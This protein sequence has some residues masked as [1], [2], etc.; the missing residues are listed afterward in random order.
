MIATGAR[1]SGYNSETELQQRA[2][3]FVDDVL[4]PL[5]ITA[6]LAGG[7]LSPADR[8]RLRRSALE[9]GLQGGRHQRAHGGTARRQRRGRCRRSTAGPRPGRPARRRRRPRADA[10][11]R[12]DGEAVLLGGGRTALAR[13]AGGRIW[14]GTSEV[15]R[16]IVTSSLER[17]GV[18]AMLG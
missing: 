16:L 5:E 6:E 10:R 17:R 9:A 15:Q 13:T 1:L 2:T 11:A 4:I 3:Q 12:L 18:R 14:E 8:S 7:A